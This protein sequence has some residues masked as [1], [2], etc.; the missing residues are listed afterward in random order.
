M[1]QDLSLGRS[2][3]PFEDTAISKGKERGESKLIWGVPSIVFDFSWKALK[4]CV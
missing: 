2:S 4:N 3:V 1:L